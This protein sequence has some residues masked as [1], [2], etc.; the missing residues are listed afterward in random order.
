MTRKSHAEGTEV[1]KFTVLLNSAQDVAGC[2]AP[3]TTRALSEFQENNGLERTA[4]L[5]QPTADEDKPLRQG[6]R[7]PSDVRQSA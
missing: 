4:A 2:C 5:D 6:Q 3:E 7:Y 1:R